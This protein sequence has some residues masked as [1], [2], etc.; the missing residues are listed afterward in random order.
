MHK[1]EHTRLNDVRTR[2]N[3]CLYIPCTYHVHSCIYMC[4]NV[5][6]WMYMFMFFN[7]C[8]Y[9]VCQLL[10]YDSIVHTLYIGT[11]STDMS[12]HVYARWSGFQ[13]I[14]FWNGLNSSM[15]SESAGQHLPGRPNRKPLN[16]VFIWNLATPYIELNRSMLRYW[17]TLKYFEVPRYRSFF[18]IEV[19]H[20]DIEV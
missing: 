20:F 14:G 7:N 15:R 19:Q 13:M 5:Y 18:D 12:V 8:I 1:H 11:E 16:L 9:H 17:S 4:R 2:L 3:H 10:Y 6:T